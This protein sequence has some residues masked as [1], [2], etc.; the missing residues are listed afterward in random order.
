MY[1]FTHGNYCGAY[2][3]DGK[4]QQSVKEG[5]KPAI[6]AW[7]RACK[8]HDNRIARGDNARS[9][10]K[11]FVQDLEQIPGI[12]SKIVRGIFNHVGYGEPRFRGTSQEGGREQARVNDTF[13]SEEIMK[14]TKIKEVASTIGKRNATR[15]ASKPKRN[16]S[17]MVIEKPP[18][19]IGTSMVAVKPTSSS[20]KDGVIVSGREFGS[21][22]YEYN[23]SSTWQVGA[24]I[25]LHPMYFASSVIGNVGRGYE[26]YRWRKLVFHFVTRQPTSVTGEIVI[27]HSEQL[28]EPCENGAASTFLPRAMT[29]GNAV[30][31]P[32]W[33]NHSLTIQCDDVYRLIDPF[34]NADI[35]EHVLGE[36][37]AYTLAAVG[38]TAGYLV[39]DYTIEFKHTMYSPHSTFL[40][41]ASGGGAQYTLLDSSSSPTAGNAVILTNSSMSGAVNGTIWKVTLN[42]ASSTLATG[43]T[44]TNAWKLIT[45]S[46][47]AVGLA[48][49]G[50]ATNVFGMQE[51]TTFYVLVMASQLFVYGSMEAAIA[52]AGSGQFFYNTTGSSAASL[53]TIAYVVRFGT[54][55]LVNAT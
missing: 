23:Q 49:V 51:G 13:T 38:D 14:K 47:T 32:L 41:L 6:D 34:I 35:D 27:T 21:A 5:G 17:G 18:V 53:S 9:A 4:F 11:L 50:T 52:G 19:T 1:P 15:M 2:W 39:M 16:I 26:R 42:L 31:G 24:M 30:I 28:L 44:N 36:V 40:P 7:D 46:A 43:T 3:S 25:P 20:T 10:N 45:Q 8:L 37:V 33:T 22:V 29:R 54:T 48:G 55:T 12:P